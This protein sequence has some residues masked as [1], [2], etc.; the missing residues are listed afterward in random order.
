MNGVGSQA[1]Q[2]LFLVAPGEVRVLR[3]DRLRIVMGKK[4]R[5]LVAALAE[6]FDPVREL[7]VQ[8]SPPRLCQATVGDFARERVLEDI[9]DLARQRGARTLPD[10]VSNLKHV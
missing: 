9:L 2:L 10:E 3:P 6:T 8:P 7:G 4:R 5:V 1:L